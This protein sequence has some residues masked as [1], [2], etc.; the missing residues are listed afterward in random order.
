M[1]T[2]NKSNNKLSKWKVFTL[3]IVAPLYTSDLRM[4]IYATT[5]KDNKKSLDTKLQSLYLNNLFEKHEKLTYNNV[6]ILKI[7][8]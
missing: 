3:H 1:F 5:Y 8:K 2:E 7:N 6:D 4:H